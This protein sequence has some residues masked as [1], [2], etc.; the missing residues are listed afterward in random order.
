MLRNYTLIAL[1][2]AGISLSAQRNFV[3]GSVILLDGQILNG[4]IDYR[5]W[6]VNPKKFS[7]R[8]GSA[9]PA[10]YTTA[11]VAGFS[12]TEKQE[13]YQRAIVDVVDESMEFDKMP[14]FESM[15]EVDPNP[16]IRRDTVFLLTLLKGKINLYSLTDKEQ[17]LHYFTQKDK[18]PFEELVYR[19]VRVIKSILANSVTAP[20]NSISVAI[21][22]RAPE[23]VHL[24]PYR[25]K[26]KQMM[27]EQPVLAAQMDKVYYSEQIVDIIRSYNE[28]SGTLT[29]VKPKDKAPKA[30][31]AFAGAGRT[32]YNLSDVFIPETAK[33]WTDQGPSF[34][35]GMDW[36]VVRTNG[37]L[38]FRLEGLFEQFKFQYNTVS[39]HVKDNGK[40]VD[41]DLEFSALRLSGQLRFSPLKTAFRPYV[42]LGFG[43]GNYLSSRF[44]RYERAPDNQEV[45][46][47]TQRKLLK[48]EMY[49]TG[50]IGFQWNNIFAE[51]RFQMGSDINRVTGED[52]KMHRLLAVAGYRLPLSGK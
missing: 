3:P 48:S 49:S 42:F 14:E 33:G 15:K 43:V 37:K 8:K 24:E 47:A 17:R 4:E 31:Y 5:E 51:G 23:I 38:S 9:S 25:M 20:R 35:L 29:Y 12:I 41:Y 10:V 27:Y 30:V 13:V 6:L 1:L 18:G 52:L 26:L 45:V 11:D 50:G 7:F 34:G 28:I 40:M 16:K 46:Q 36:G 44:D 22:S 19:Q 21:P 32:V 2:M 39:P